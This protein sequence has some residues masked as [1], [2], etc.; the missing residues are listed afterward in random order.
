MDSK[1]EGEAGKEA[2]KAYAALVEDLSHN[3]G[4]TLNLYGKSVWFQ[5]A[6]RRSVIS[7]AKPG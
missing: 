2:L 6:A 5:C 4:W 3:W 1:E 7:P